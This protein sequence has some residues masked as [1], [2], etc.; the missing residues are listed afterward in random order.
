ML[1]D[2]REDKYVKLL[3]ALTIC[4]GEAMV[5]NQGVISEILL[6]NP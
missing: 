4:D 6:E 1:L 5:L 2:D 3:R